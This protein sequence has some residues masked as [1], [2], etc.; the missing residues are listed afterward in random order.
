MSTRTWTISILF[1]FRVHEGSVV[2]ARKWHCEPLCC[3]HLR[4]E[5]QHY[6]F[7]HFLVQT[8]L[9]DVV[10]FTDFWFY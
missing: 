6:I 1:T 4:L 2:C 3:R 8:G 5:F 9:T 7:L 10:N